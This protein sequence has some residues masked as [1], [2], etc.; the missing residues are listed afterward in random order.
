MTSIVVAADWYFDFISPFAYLQGERLA[1]LAPQIRIRYRPV[2]FAG[3]LAAN[4]H[5]GPAEIAS[6]RV[7]TYRFVV[8]QADKLGIP[9]RFPHEHPFNP[10]PLLRLAIACDCAPDAVH[11]IFRF[12]WRDGRLPDLPIEWAELADDLG[13]RDAAARIADPDVK[14][15]LRANTDEAIGRGV[16][17]VPTLAIDDTLFWGLDA[18]EMARDYVTAGRRFVD[19]EYERVATLP[20]GAQR[21]EAKAP[22]RARTRVVGTAS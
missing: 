6:K 16:F 7:F 3:L 11:R 14:N 21:S 1:S 10:L 18:T 20:E 13:I 4:G 19:P 8:W 15:A 5:K 2:L 9:L 17:G 12:V 22:K